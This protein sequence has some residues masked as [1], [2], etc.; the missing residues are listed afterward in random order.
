M[1]RAGRGWGT[2]LC[3]LTP[4]YC[5]W[6]RTAN[7]V[8]PPRRTISPL[9]T[10]IASVESC[11]V[12]RTRQIHCHVLPKLKRKCYRKSRM[13]IHECKVKQI[14][15]RDGRGGEFAFL[16]TFIS[17]SSWWAEALCTHVLGHAGQSVVSRAAYTAR[18]EELAV[19]S[20]HARARVC[21][22]VCV[23]VCV[24]GF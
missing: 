8:N 18:S 22:F 4:R 15:Y 3:L 7:G 20:R 13:K 24:C 2:V 14:H 21:V 17:T 9:W 5:C 11:R 19:L 10:W 1:Y 23:C 6:M 12:F 16:K